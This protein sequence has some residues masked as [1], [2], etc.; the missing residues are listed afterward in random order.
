MITGRTPAVAPKPRHRSTRPVGRPAWSSGRRWDIYEPHLTKL[1]R[2]STCDSE[3]DTAQRDSEKG[4][5]G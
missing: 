3:G 1:S 2:C 4:D 5:D